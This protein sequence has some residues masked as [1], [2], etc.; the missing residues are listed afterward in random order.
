MY[1]QNLKGEGKVLNKG[2]QIC[3]INNNFEKHKHVKRIETKFRRF[4]DVMKPLSRNRSKI[5]L[6]L[7]LDNGVIMSPKRRNFVLLLFTCLKIC[8]KHYKILDKFWD[9]EL[10][11]DY[12]TMKGQV[13]LEG[14][15]G[16]SRHPLVDTHLKSKKGIFSKGSIFFGGGRYCL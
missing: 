16:G 11:F 6:L 7:F 15:G 1:A 13:S 8:L 2:T 4:S 10:C 9:L 3:L 5:I 14:V 12:K